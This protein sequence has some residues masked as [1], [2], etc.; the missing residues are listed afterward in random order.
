[1][2][3]PLGFPT[4]SLLYPESRVIYEGRQAVRVNAREPS[5]VKSHGGGGGGDE[6]E[7]EERN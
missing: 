4:I 2:L 6:K 7:E 1:M 5:V 3:K